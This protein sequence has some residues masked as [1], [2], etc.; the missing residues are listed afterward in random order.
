MIKIEI[1]P[2]LTTK[3]NSFDPLTFCFFSAVIVRDKGRGRKVG[4]S[5]EI[6]SNNVLEDLWT[7]DIYIYLSLEK[8]RLGQGEYRLD[9]SMQREQLRSF[10][11]EEKN[12]HRVQST[13]GRGYFGMRP[14]ARRWIVYWTVLI[15][16]CSA[17]VLPRNTK[18]E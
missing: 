12:S 15:E 1:E 6:K 10:Y 14:L 18:I 7:I 5:V 16:R 9:R 2:S 4:R 11:E 3:K 8:R 17:N 13:K